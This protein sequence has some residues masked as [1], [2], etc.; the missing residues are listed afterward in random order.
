MTQHLLLVSLGPV[1]DFIA[2]ARRTRD[3]WFGSHVLSMLSQTAA[4]ALLRGGGELIIPA[5]PDGS[6]AGQGVPNKLMVLLRQGDPQTLAQAARDAAKKHLREWGREQWEKHP[7]LVNP[8]SEATA[9]EQLDTFLEFHAA[10]CAFS[11]PE[12][13]AEALKHSE[14]AL[15]GHKRLRT[16][17]PWH[18]QRGGVHKSSLDGARE[19]VLAEGERHHGKWK[20][21]RIGLR[22]QLDAMGLLKRTGGEPGQFIPVPTIGLAA[23][24]G[25]AHETAPKALEALVQACGQLRGQEGPALTRVRSGNKP[26]VNPFPFDAQLLLP[27]RWSTHLEEQDVPR[28]QA[29]HFGK[30]FVQPLLNA[31]GEPFPYVACLVADGDKMGKVLQELA[32]EG[33]EAHRRLSLKLSGFAAEARRIVEQHHRGV[34]VYAGGDDVLAFVCLPDALSCAA[35]LR[36]AFL[37]AMGE[38]LAG[39]DIHA[40]PT[41]S[42][43][44]GVGHVLESLGDLLALG[45]S[46]EQLA[47]SED[48]DGFALRARLRSS[49]EH[50]WRMR[51]PEG[52]VEALTRAIAL[53]REGRLPLTKVQEVRGLLRRMPPSHTTLPEAQRWGHVLSREVGRVLARVEIGTPGK[54]LLPSEAGLPLKP[55]AA[56]EDV[57]AQVT[58]WTECLALAELFLRADPWPRQAKG[59]VP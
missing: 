9:Q 3:L 42:V 16:F 20:Q 2:Q 21:F 46:A 48:R 5:L 26:W 24:T 34:L 31:L 12:E 53:R 54:G 6:E 47:K 50:A 45:R 44:L 19:S 14:A 10:W 39:L 49:T 15:A 29:A 23:Y 18:H 4:Q 33:P 30:S 25:R 57:H 13:Y 38:A 28:E 36:Q 55:G 8:A 17:A 11:T 52:P 51:W 40:P 35:Q 22:E 58:A 59:G 1:Q 56:L 43:G 41:L 27:G 32:K 37:C 7:Q